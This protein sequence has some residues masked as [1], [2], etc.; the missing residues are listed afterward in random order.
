M[1]EHSAPAGTSGL[2]GDESPQRREHADLG[3]NESP[4]TFPDHLTTALAICGPPEA[5]AASA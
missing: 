4:Q 2:A 3:G 5:G 1:T